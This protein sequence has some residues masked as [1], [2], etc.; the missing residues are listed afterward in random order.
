MKDLPV[1]AEQ[2][3]VGGSW[4][5]LPELSQT[6]WNLLKQ[7]ALN[8]LLPQINSSTSLPNMLYELKDMRTLKRSNKRI[9][10]GIDALNRLRGLGNAVF[11]GREARKTLRSLLRSVSDSYLQTSFNLAPLLRD[12]A[13]LRGGLGSLL[14]EIETLK[15]RANTPQKRHYRC[16]L[17][18]PYL[19]EDTTLSLTVNPSLYLL[20]SGLTASRSVRYSVCE[21]TAT[22]D[23]SY[24]LPSMSDTELGVRALLDKL[25][26]NLNPSIIWNALPWSFV[27]DWVFGVSRWLDQYKV[28]M[29]EPTIRISG[30]CCAAHVTRVTECYLRRAQYAGPVSTVVEEVYERK[31]GLNQAEVT[32]S[33]QS[34]GLNLKEL[35]LSA[36]LAF[37]R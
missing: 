18:G 25:G 8:A 23:Y 27:V 11:K 30:F 3:A 21:F 29:L 7:R 2:S 19:A 10:Q 24:L 17:T 15:D 13:A 22:I 36:A 28:R 14:H 34:S 16:R 5:F 33:I 35:S 20:E 32:S 9:H 6:D 26:V 12:I 37:S 4:S 1:L 31:V